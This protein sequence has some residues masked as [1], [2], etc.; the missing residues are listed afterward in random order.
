MKKSKEEMLLLKNKKLIAE[1]RLIISDLIKYVKYA[2]FLKNE[3][4]KRVT[5]YAFK[6]PQTNYVY[7]E[8]GKRIGKLT[9]EQYKKKIGYKGCNP[10]NPSDNKSKI[11]IVAIL[12]KK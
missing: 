7:Y 11:N 10:S 8:E 1:Q 12:P 5:F 6:D 3:I 2:D 9:H 4:K